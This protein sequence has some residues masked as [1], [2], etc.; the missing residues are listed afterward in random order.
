[1]ATAVESL[2]QLPDAARLT[3]VGGWDEREEARLQALA[4]SHGVAERVHFAGQLPARDVRA[5][6]DATDVVVFPV[7]WEE[8]WGL[9]PLEAM[10][11]GRPVVA[12]GRGGSGEYLRDAENALL[13]NPGDA[14]A[15]ASAV[16]RIADEPELRARLRE[17]GLETAARNTERQFNERVLSEVSSAVPE[18]RAPRPVRAAH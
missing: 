11:R 10:A 9:V 3:I 7:I 18:G 8:P 12:T 4:D 2:A 15:L 14:V 17:H 6:Y 16:R 13:F 5:A 1:M